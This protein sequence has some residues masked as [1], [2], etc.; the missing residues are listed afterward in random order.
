[1]DFITQLPKSLAEGCSMVWVIVDR[2]TKM[3]HFVPVKDGQK[4]AEGC[5]KLFLE[6]IWKLHGLPNSIISD[7]DPV[8]TSKFWA[9]LMGR[10]DVR[11]R[12]STAFHPKTDGQTER[13]NQS[14]E[15]YL[16][17]YCNY[18]QDNWNDLLPLAEYTYY[19][20][21][22]TATQMSPFF[23][24]YG[25]H[26]RINWPVEKESKNPTSRNYAHWMESV[27]ELCVKGLEET[28]ERM[29]KYYDRLRK[30]APPYSVGDVVMFNGK[31]IRTRRAAKK[32]DANLK[33]FGALKVVRLVGQGG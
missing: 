27:P 20:S 12:K 31:N 10:L 4:T 24:N 25:F 16:R 6:N 11:L 1:M 21:A 5:A 9:E 18:E 26:P 32:L 8:F 33:L 28:R 2:F 7:R 17:Q 3:A 14:L 15:Q 29:G 30:E 23:E 13:V 19:N 22:T